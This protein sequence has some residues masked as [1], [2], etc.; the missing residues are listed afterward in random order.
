MHSIAQQGPGEF[1]PWWVCLPGDPRRR[2]CDPDASRCDRAKCPW[3]A[4]A[5]RQPALRGIRHRNRAPARCRAQVLRPARGCKASKSR[6]SAALPR[7]APIFPDKRT[8]PNSPTS[9]TSLPRN[10]GLR[11]VS[12][13][14]SRGNLHLVHGPALRRIVDCASRSRPTADTSQPNASAPIFTPSSNPKQTSQ[15]TRQAIRARSP[16]R[17]E[18]SRVSANTLVARAEHTKRL[19]SCANYSGSRLSYPTPAI[20]R[21]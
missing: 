1:L 7:P 8:Q 19:P 13:I 18:A 11:Q 14:A 3:R 4:D 16:G 20:S 17:R 6:R 21:P 12:P 15:R 5:P 9:L 10:E 2:P